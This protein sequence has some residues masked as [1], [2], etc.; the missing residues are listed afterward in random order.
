MN[1]LLICV[2]LAQAPDVDGG[3]PDAPK[4]PPV[5]VTSATSLDGGTLPEGWYLSRE[6]MQKVGTKLVT[7]ENENQQ[8][9][10]GRPIVH[11]GFWVG[12][13]VGF[14]AG[15]GGTILVVEQIHR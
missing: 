1:S 4:D 13:A 15:V 7:L 12:I 9:K 8:L 2:L 10:D 14:V 6:R 5:E 11:W 3:V